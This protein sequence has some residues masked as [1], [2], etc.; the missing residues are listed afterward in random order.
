MTTLTKYQETLHD[1]LEACHIRFSDIKPSDWV[2]KHRIMS[3][4][5]SNFQGQFSYKWTPYCREIVDCMM[6]DHPARVIAVMKGAQIGFSTGVIEPAIGWT[7]AENPCNVLFLTG[8]SDLAEE[9]ITKIDSLIDSCGIRHLIKP[10]VQRARNT[11]TG[12][13][14]TKKEFAG[15]SLVSGSAGN[16]KLLRQRS[17]KV[18]FIDDF[19][20]AKGKTKESGNTRKMIEQRLAAYYDK[21][22]LY[23]ISTPEINPSNIEEVYLLGDQRKYHVPCPC[24]GEFITLEWSVEQEGTKEMAGMTWKLDES[25]RLIRESIGYICQKCGGFFPEKQ[26]YEMNLHGMWLPTAT[27]QREGNYSY[28]ISALYA[29]PGMYN[30]EHYVYEYLEANPPDGNRKE[31]LHQTFMN[32]CLGLPYEKSAEEVKATEL[33]KNIRSY[34]IGI[35][36][37]KLSMEDGNGRIVLLTLGCDLNGKL[38]DARLDYEIVAYSENGATYSIKHGSIGTFIPREGK[39]GKDRERWTYQH[40][41]DKSVWKELERILSYT[42]DTDTGRRMRIFIAGVDIGYETTHAWQFINSTNNFVIGL[43]GKDMDKY[44]PYNRDAK[45]FKKSLEN[46]KLYLVEANICK[47]K[48]AEHMRLKWDKNLTDVQP[49][50]F[51]NFPEPSGGKYLFENYFAHFEAEHRKIDKDGYYRWVKKSDVHQ[52]H[53]FDCRI[54]ANVT[55]DILVHNVCRE[56]KIQNGTWTDY[57]DMLLKRR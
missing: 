10:S 1:I 12:D 18:A 50:G 29:P 32:L 23:Y 39:N 20:A 15:G 57:C 41:M 11:K 13:T 21:M 55:R 7:I 43:K 25:N 45:T 52:N 56:L 49:S 36:P 37:E 3:S 34:E 19:E 47:D 33:Q 48:L 16:H 46:P 51:M 6:P 22:K 42:Y 17:V 30:W 9:A 31:D 27:P 40:G 54:Y 35:I 4:A 28:H 8:H 2:E 38:D 53:L 14:N 5:E 26:K 44:V 24:C